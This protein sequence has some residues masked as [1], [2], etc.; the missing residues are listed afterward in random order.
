MERSR[1]DFRHNRPLQLMVGWLLLYWI[2]TAISPFN[3]LDW[4]LENLL[5]FFYC[6]LLS[7]TYRRFTFS[8]RS[9]GLFVL[10]LTL[11]LTGAHY[12][13]AETPVGYW[14]ME[15]LDLSR[16]H[17]DRVAHF[18]YGLLCGYPLFELLQRRACRN[19]HWAG[20]LAVTMIIGFSAFFE[21]VESIIAVIVSPELGAA[22]LGIQ[23]DEWDAQKDMGLALLG[24]IVAITITFAWPKGV[25]SKSP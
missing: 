6:G 10:F 23:G 12:T 15:W 25:S 4:F 1:P 2:V 21:V 19:R 20:F 18:A 9:Y 13:Y 17:F 22:Y 11:H 5:V 16:N 8:N 14:L 3:R 24:A 7:A